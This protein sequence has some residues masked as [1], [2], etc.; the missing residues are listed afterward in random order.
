MDRLDFAGLI[1]SRIC[2][3]LAGPIGA[4]AG[5]AELL[6]DEADEAV[7][8]EF[9]TVMGTG[10][11]TLAARLRLL[12]LLFGGGGGGGSDTPIPLAE[13]RAILAAWFAID[14][15]VALDWADASA[16]VPLPLARL[17]LA[18]ALTAADALEHGGHIAIAPAADGWRIVGAGP[19]VALA[20]EHAAILVGAD[21]MAAGSRA[22]TAHLAAALAQR[23]ETSIVITQS[24]GGLHLAVQ[25]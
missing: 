8:A 3:D 10:A 21:A 5:G 18:L 7:C 20:P 9:L 17:L 13:V 1:A 12:R 24:Q 19:H 2:H 15:R 25:G 23:L 16:V 4:I 6:G 14:A 22:A 11:A